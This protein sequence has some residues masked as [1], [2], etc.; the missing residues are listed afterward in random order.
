MPASARVW[1]AT[2]RS[3]SELAPPPQHFSTLRCGPRAR[4]E[5]APP[6]ARSSTAN[7]SISRRFR[8]RESG[9]WPCKAR[10]FPCKGYPPPSQATPD[11]PCSIASS[12]PLNRVARPSPG[13][14]LL[15]SFNSKV[16]ISAL[17]MASWSASARSS[18]CWVAWCSR[19][20]SRACCGGAQPFIESVVVR[21]IRRRRIHSVLVDSSLPSRE[22]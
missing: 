11:A 14:V 15:N 10:G 7:R 17:A 16:P 13:A 18:P 9:R 6:G 1:T 8:L 20:I 19:V 22:A 4:H 3:R 21:G 12:S 5:V 2:R